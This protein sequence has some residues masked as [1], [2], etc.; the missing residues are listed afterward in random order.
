M[1]LW[2]RQPNGADVFPA[3]KF[4]YPAGVERATDATAKMFWSK[5]RFASTWII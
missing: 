5:K 2:K 1:P 4:A 3:S